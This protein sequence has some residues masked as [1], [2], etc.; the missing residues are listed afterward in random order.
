MEKRFLFILIYFCRKPPLIKISP[1]INTWQLCRTP[2]NCSE[3]PHHTYLALKSIFF[4]I[5]VFH[6]ITVCEKK[7]RN[8]RFG[9]WCAGVAICGPLLWFVFVCWWFVV[10]CGGL[11]VVCGHLWS[12][13]VL[14]TT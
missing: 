2:P 14:V 3:P 8:V 11:L 1:L 7:K 5:E 9:V 4:K 12:L 10:V 13:P 6:V